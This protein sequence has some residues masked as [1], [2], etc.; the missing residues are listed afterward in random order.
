MNGRWRGVLARMMTLSGLAQRGFFIPYRYAAKL[1]GSGGRPSYQE[2]EALLQSRADAF[3]TFLSTIDG[4]GPELERIG[5]EPPPAPRWTQDW[6]PRLDA[7]A[8]YA[9]VRSLKP[10]RI[11]EVGAGH[12][13]RFVVR[14]VHAAG[15]ATLRLPGRVP[16]VG[17]GLG[18]E[19][20]S[21]FLEL[22]PAAGRGGE[23]EYGD[24]LAHSHGS[25]CVSSVEGNGE[26]GICRRPRALFFDK[27]GVLDGRQCLINADQ[28]G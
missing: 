25:L 28:D 4:F 21:L 19:L 10:R 5:T 14:A 26:V 27:C 15:Q 17:A 16:A 13:T 12:S 8:A 2:V 20:L 23:D 7:A 3:H 22:D 18:L 6:F 24:D 11:V 1:S 9:L